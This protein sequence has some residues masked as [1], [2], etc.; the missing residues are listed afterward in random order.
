MV[1]YCYDEITIK[2]NCIFTL[3]S[4]QH[5]FI[6]LDIGEDQIYGRLLIQ[7]T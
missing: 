4:D 6:K 5:V 3:D 7:Y 1:N 2:I